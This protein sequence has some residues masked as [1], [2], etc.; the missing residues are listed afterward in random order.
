MFDKEYLKKIEA[1]KKRW[2]ETTLKERLAQ[3]KEAKEVF[4]TDSQLEVNRLYTPLDLEAIGFDYL[5]D[6]SWP[7]EYPFARGIDPIMYR[8]APWIMMQYSG[9]ASAEETNKRFKFMLSQGASS[10]SIALDLPTHKALDSDDPLAEGEV[11]KVGVPIDSLKSLEAIF[12][13]IPL[14]SVK[15]FICVAMSTG[16]IILPLFLSLAEKAGIDPRRFGLFMTNEAL[17]EFACRGTQFTTPAGHFRLSADVVE[18]CA[19]N[20]PNFSPLQLSGYHAREAGCTAIQELAFPLANCITYIE[21]LKKRGLSIDDYTGS[22]TWFFSSSLD[23]LEEVAKFRAFRKIWANIAK[24]R[25]GAKNPKAMHARIMIYTGGSNL[26]RR[27]PYINIVR[28]TIQ[29]LSS[30]LAGVQYMNLS[31]FDE[32]YQTPTEEGATI[33][34]RTQQI[35]ANESGVTKT[36]DPLAG[37]YYVETLTKKIETEVYD[38]LQKIENMGGAVKA[39]EKGFYQSEIADQ[40]FRYNREI[41]SKERIKVALN[42][43]LTDQEVKVAPLRYDPDAEK[44]TVEAVRQLRRERDNNRVKQAL[45][46][47]RRT[48]KGTENAIPSI[49]EAV[50]AYATV[51]EIS[52]AMRDVFGEYREPNIL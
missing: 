27:Q 3:G 29:A 45:E 18:Y 4:K 41:E 37:S 36:V 50:K 1:E 20:F 48:L 14:D 52:N 38:Y 33:A 15:M 16:P 35:L 22:F 13:G 40:A 21:E 42:E 43:F 2:E 5:K 31:S 10:F 46:N 8:A 12:D 34:V 47:V 9:F 19:R 49:V 30:A 39:I 28:T 23:L 51:G 6:T 7:G 11:G 44:K 26:T 17:M 24:N 25:F 32:A